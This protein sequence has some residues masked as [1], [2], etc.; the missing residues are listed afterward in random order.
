MKSVLVAIVVLVAGCASDLPAASFI[1]KLRV[2]AV[3]AQS[4]EVAPGDT[5]AL[6][7]LAVEP[8]IPQL[9]GSAPRPLTAVWLAGALP[10]GTRKG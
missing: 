10:A 8:R 2:L 4:P 9:D 7:V 5:T 6:H 1:D 3:Q